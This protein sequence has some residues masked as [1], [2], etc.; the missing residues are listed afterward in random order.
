M[1]DDKLVDPATPDAQNAY[2]NTVDRLE[3]DIAAIDR[4][5]VLPSIAISLRRIADTLCKRNQHGDTA[6]DRICRAII[7]VADR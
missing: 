5:A 3:P 2:L 1:D 4:D 7:T 6:I